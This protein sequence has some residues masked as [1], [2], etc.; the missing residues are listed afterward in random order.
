MTIHPLKTKFGNDSRNN[1]VH[2]R[3]GEQAFISYGRMIATRDTATGAISLDSHYWDYSTTTG[4][5][6][7]Q[8]LGET[9]TAT[10]KKINNGTYTLT[11]LE[12]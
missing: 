9:I 7:N 12:Y 11:T 1:F 3:G 4:Y 10:R 6:R 2:T 5:Y 8:F